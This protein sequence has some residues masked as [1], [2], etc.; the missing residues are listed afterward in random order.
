MNIGHDLYPVSCQ[1]AATNGLAPSPLRYALVTPARNEAGY[2]GKTLESVV[3]Q[4]LRPVRWV[5]VSDG[6]TDGTDELVRSFAAR[7]DWIELVRLPDRAQ[8][9]FAAKVTAFNAG[10]ARFQ[11][12]NCNIELTFYQITIGCGPTVHRGH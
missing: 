7:H 6:S 12:G 1:P 5:I 8:R 2:I 11:F 10:L 4:T 9:D 3:A